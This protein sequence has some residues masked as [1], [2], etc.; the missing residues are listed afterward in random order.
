MDALRRRI[1]EHLAV[2][3]I[4]VPQLHQVTLNRSQSP[5]AQDL[6]LPSAFSPA[7][8][9]EYG[10]VKLAEQ[11][12]Q[13]RIGN[14]HDHLASLRDGLGLR[15]LLV[16]AKQA[17][18]RGQVKTT[19]SEASIKRA[20]AVVE[21]H[22]AGY[23]RNWDAMK[24]LGVKTGAGNPGAGLQELQKNDLQSL[25]HFVDDRSYTGN[26]ADLPWIWRISGGLVGPNTVSGDV[27][28][29]VESWEREGE[30]PFT[31]A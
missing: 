26:P 25:R 20:G 28:K 9:K 31:E 30:L 19:R 13:L 8:R 2:L 10:M 3:L 22:E 4:L 6:F 7:Q 12:A 14:A 18:A 16:Q 21:R 15:S 5:T 17:H 24:K 11:E 1:D 23:N 27:R 29:A